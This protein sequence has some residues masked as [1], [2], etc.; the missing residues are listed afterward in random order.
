LIAAVALLAVALVWL[1]TRFAAPDAYDLA[2]LVRVA[3]TYGSLLAIGLVLAIGSVRSRFGGY[4]PT[5]PADVLAIMAVVG[6]TVVCVATGQPLVVTLLV[7]LI[8]LLAYPVVRGRLGSVVDRAVLGDLRARSAI[9]AIER[10]RERVSREIHD[11]PLQSLSVLVQRLSARPELAGEAAL[12]R[13][14]SEQL[15]DATVQLHPP[16]LQDLGLG[17]ALAYLVER[18]RPGSDTRVTLELDDRA[19]RAPESRPPADVELA[20]YRIV[21]E[22]LGNALR[23]SGAP[24]I[25]VSGRIEP[26]RIEL[27]VTDDGVGIDQ[28]ATDQAR[29]RG[30]MGLRSMSERAHLIG[31]ELRIG[32]DT[33]GSSVRVRWPA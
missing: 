22:A 9:E 20:L 2:D 18:S 3:A 21:Q 10:E 31:G 33:D 12:L 26:A 14:V 13:S 23:H 7:A 27:A 16:I 4:D 29:S 24:T 1:A 8:P 5:R 19:G 28:V 32:G 25:V 6:A 15:R 17:P 11:E 30:R